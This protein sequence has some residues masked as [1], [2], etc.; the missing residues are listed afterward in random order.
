[1]TEK[2][3]LIVLSGPSGVGKGTVRQAIFSKGERDFI[4]SISATT[5]QR[6]EGEVD[7][8]DYFFKTREEFEDMIKNDQL[9]EYTEYV[10]NYYGTPVDYVQKT[11]DAGKDIFL[12]IEV[13]GAMQVKERMPE[14]TYIFLT[15]PNMDELEAR[16]VNRGTDESPVIRQRMEKAIEEIELM[17]YY[18]YA[19]E[20]DTVE[21]AVSKVL[22][23]IQ[24]EHLK[25]SRLL[26]SK[27]PNQGE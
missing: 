27:L 20:N 23:I 3:L 18:D 8:V 17:R 21:N 1:M 2:G 16:I 26:E 5:R 11:I 4:Y 24:S 25:V 12:E 14:G 6:R 15:P 9:L 19:V 13:Q 7:G 22:A 10:G